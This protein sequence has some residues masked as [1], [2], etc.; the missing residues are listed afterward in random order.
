MQGSFNS[1]SLFYFFILWVFIFFF[2]YIL[3]V[4]FV[5]T[6][7][8]CMYVYMYVGSVNVNARFINNMS[9]DCDLPN[10]GWIKI[11]PS[12]LFGGRSWRKKKKKWEVGRKWLHVRGGGVTTLVSPLPLLHR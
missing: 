9:R 3:C 8:V 11:L 12:Y 5:C 6:F 1:N 10:T 2:M 7:F 4:Y